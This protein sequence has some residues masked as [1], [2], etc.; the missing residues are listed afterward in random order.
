LPT[1]DDSS[2]EEN[3]RA[4]KVSNHSGESMESSNSSLGNPNVNTT[5]GGDGL[6]FTVG[7]PCVFELINRIKNDKPLV[8]TDKSFSSEH[9][10]SEEQEESTEE[11]E[12]EDEVLRNDIDL[13][14]TDLPETLKP[15]SLLIEVCQ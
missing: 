7:Q 11:A 6:S 2:D 10:T 9:V 4:S 8:N 13:T 12:E 15:I 1:K 14:M 3:M 5:A